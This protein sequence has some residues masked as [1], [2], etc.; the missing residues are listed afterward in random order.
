MQ[1]YNV[2]KMLARSAKCLKSY[3]CGKLVF[4]GSEPH[5]LLLILAPLKLVFFCLGLDTT[6]GGHILDFCF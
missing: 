3:S 1:Y 5:L 4:T 6:F 2:I